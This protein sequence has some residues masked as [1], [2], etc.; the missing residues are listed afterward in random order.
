M[1]SGA[2]FNDFSPVKRY[3]RMHLDTTVPIKDLGIEDVVCLILDPNDSAKM[4]LV[5]LLACQGDL[6]GVSGG[7]V[8]RNGTQL[9][10]NAGGSAQ[11]LA[12]VP[13]P[14]EHVFVVSTRHQYDSFAFGP[15]PRG[16]IRGLIVGK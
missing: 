12:A 11:E 5:G 1:D 9:D 14:A 3:E 6:V 7:K 10:M 13:V 8:V 15:I 4:A 16:S 2:K